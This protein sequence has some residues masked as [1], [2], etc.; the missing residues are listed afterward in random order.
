VSYSDTPRSKTKP[1]IDGLQRLNSIF[2]FIENEYLVA[3]AYFDLET[4]AETKLR[5]DEGEL[6]QRT[7]ILDLIAV[8]KLRGSPARPASRWC[9]SRA[10]RFRQCRAV[11]RVDAIELTYK[12]ADGGVCAA[13]P[14][15]SVGQPS[16]APA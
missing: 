5:R 6:A 4:L 2:A 16:H 1:I 7:P 15:T 12:T 9:D 13:A 10:A 11:A 3:G 14:M 8:S